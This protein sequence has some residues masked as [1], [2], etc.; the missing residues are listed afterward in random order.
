MTFDVIVL[1]LSN[2]RGF[3][4]VGESWMIIICHRTSTR[5]SAAGFSCGKPSLFNPR[6]SSVPVLEHALREYDTISQWT[7]LPNCKRK[8][9]RVRVYLLDMQMRTPW[10]L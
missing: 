9:R 7:T 6:A 4:R 2:G 5:N 10:A 1:Q 3:I 8:T